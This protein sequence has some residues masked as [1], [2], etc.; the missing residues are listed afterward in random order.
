MVA[1]AITTNEDI[2]C[3]DDGETK[4]LRFGKYTGVVVVVDT[5]VHD[6][7]SMEYF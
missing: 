2:R 6:G 4:W 3:D 1:T 7:V 5:V